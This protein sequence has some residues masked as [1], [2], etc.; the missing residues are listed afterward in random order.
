MAS[1]FTSSSASAAQQQLEEKLALAEKNL[2]T[3]V[4]QLH[5]AE[6]D[7]ADEIEELKAEHAKALNRAQVHLR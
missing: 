4:E 2:E 3:V 1:F 5:A 7:H 6:E